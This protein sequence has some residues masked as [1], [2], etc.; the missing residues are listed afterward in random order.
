MKLFNHIPNIYFLGI[1]GIGMSALAQYFVLNG[2][3]V[4]GYDKTPG[5]MTKKLNELGVKISFEDNSKQIPESFDNPKNTLVVYTP[6]VPKDLEIL[7]HFKSAGFQIEKRA[8]VLG[9]ITEEIP[10]LAVAGTHGKTTTSAI[11]AHLLKQSGFEITAFLGGIAENY[12]SNFIYDGKDACVVE[13]DEYDRSFLQLSPKYAAITS[14]DPDHLDI[15]GDEE[16]LINSFK[17]F[18]DKLPTTNRLFYKKGLNL[19]GNSIG[20]ETEA[21]FEIKNIKIRSGQYHFDLKH[22]DK[23]I[24]NFEFS[25][26]GRHNLMNAGMALAMAISFGATPDNLKEALQSFKGV[27]R[28]FSYRLKTEQLVVVEDYAHH[29]EEIKAVYQ[30]AREM[31]PDK[32]IMAVFQPHLYSRTKDFAEEFAMSLSKFDQ[33]VLL[34]IYPARELPIPG[35]DS[36]Y[37]LSLMSTTK[38]KLIDK[39]ELAETVKD[40]QPEVV[41]V[42][43]A[44]DIGNEVEPLLKTLRDEN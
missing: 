31:Y 34:P 41:L 36:E 5:K 42:L 17:E 29:P 21:D 43:G 44:G 35:I 22:E 15:Y 13:A 28:R 3:Q 26:P 4:A 11:L 40:L 20:I 1:G 14:M 24:A 33:V 10:T 12:N 19:E 16:E 2:K 7:K 30:A 23:T 38:K 18:S 6:A 25:L 37:L 39:N 8:V 32:N 9:K 27:D